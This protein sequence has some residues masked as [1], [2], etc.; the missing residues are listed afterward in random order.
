MFESRFVGNPEDRFYHVEAQL[1]LYSW[2]FHPLKLQLV[3]PHAQN[4]HL[5]VWTVV[6]NQYPALPILSPQSAVLA[7]VTSARFLSKE[8][9]AL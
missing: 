1:Y 9:T 4:I 7:S 8:I 6:K 5:K 3:K 2:Y